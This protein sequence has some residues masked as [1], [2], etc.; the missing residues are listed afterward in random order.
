MKTAVK[1]WVFERVSFWRLNVI[2]WSAFAVFSLVERLLLFPT[3][4]Q[5][6][7]FSIAQIPLAVGISGLMREVFRRRLLPDD[8]DVRTAAVV[9][10]L[11][12][13]AAT[14]HAAIVHGAAQWLQWNESQ[15][16]EEAVFGLRMKFYWLVYMGWGL[17]Y[18]GI[19]AEREAAKQAARARRAAE[20]ARDFELQLLRSQL[21][22]HFL[23]NSL[24]SVAAEIRPH[25]DS[26]I[27]MVCELSD[28]LRYSLDHRNQ[29]TGQLKAELEAVEAY[30]KIQKARFGER[31]ITVIDVDESA[32]HAVVPTFLLQ[33]LVENA[34]KHGLDKT[35][36]VWELGIQA[37][38]M[39]DTLA[40]EVRNTGT[41]GSKKRRGHGVGLSTLRR[42]LEL[43]YPGRHR[44][45]LVQEKNMVCARLRLTGRPV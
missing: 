24:N 31:L 32:R 5:A 37:R 18:F 40:V 12:L 35:G 34:A 29:R 13:L 22:P 26:A 21:D 20:D 38:M 30:L 25:P 39:V 1:V 43:L 33:P 15:L 36:G 45:D 9:I 2:V 11:G 41:L 16:F 7:V 14:L 17:G 3:P 8:F 28:Y 19:R 4:W 6:I 27:S 10:V 42:R 44:F 23:F